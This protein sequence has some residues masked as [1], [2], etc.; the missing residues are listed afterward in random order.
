MNLFTA[1]LI[2]LITMLVA[3]SAI[4]HSQL[5]SARKEVDVCQQQILMLK[6]DSE[7]QEARVEQ[8]NA[9]AQ[10]QVRQI[11]NKAQAIL[12]TKV[13]SNCE[14]SIKWLIKQAHSL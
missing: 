5:N 13:S 1:I 7:Q 10:A 14:E 2:A 8:A 11:Q 6:L 12:R 3:I 4:Q 9:D